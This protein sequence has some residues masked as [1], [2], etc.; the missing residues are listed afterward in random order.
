MESISSLV[1]KQR[2]LEDNLYKKRNRLYLVCKKCSP[3]CELACLL[4]EAILILIKKIYAIRAII[5]TEVT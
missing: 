3:D 4:R 1:Q 5:K 2:V